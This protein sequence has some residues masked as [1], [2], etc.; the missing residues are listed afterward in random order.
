MMADGEMKRPESMPYEEYRAARA[1]EAERVR[2]H[3]QG[4]YITGK[5]RGRSVADVRRELRT[6]AASLLPSGGVR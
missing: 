3:L 1:R 5:H 2:D 4:R 6:V